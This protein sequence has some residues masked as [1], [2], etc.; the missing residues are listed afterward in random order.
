LAISTAYDILFRRLGGKIPV[1]FLR[2]LSKSES[3]QNPA[4]TGG[5]YWGLLQVGRSMIEGYN[6][7]RGTRY[8]LSDVLD[9]EVNVAIGSEGLGRIVT[10]YGKHPDRNLKA[11]WASPEFV[12]LVLAGWNSGYSE[13]GGV[14]R[15]ARYLEERSIPVTHDNVFMYAAAAGATKHLSNIKKRNWQ[16]SVADLYFAQ[17]DRPTGTLLAFAALLF[18]GWGI[19]RLATR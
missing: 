19:Y 6:R 4:E 15:V 9:P 10:S 17:P 14:G 1:P 11:N 3:N 7:R 5:S 18:V 8:T 16:R 12:K 13:A 2:A